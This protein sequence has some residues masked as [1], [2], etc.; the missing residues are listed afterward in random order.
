[1]DIYFCDLC[2]V[3]VT[4][5]DLRSGHGIRSRFDVI[6]GTCLELGHGK[7][8][9]SQRAKPKVGATAAAGSPTLDA[10]RDRVG[11]LE[12]D[13]PRPVA[14][15]IVQADAAPAAGVPIE[16]TPADA[17]PVLQETDLTSTAKVRTPGAAEPMNLA[18]AANMFSAL[19]EAP[20]PAAD[21]SR[22]NA[23]I[24]DDQDDLADAAD[25]PASEDTSPS[26]AQ[27]VIAEAASPFSFKSP[28]KDETVSTP[29]L[30]DDL[31]SEDEALAEVE[32]VRKDK[33]KAASNRHK[34]AGTTS[35]RVPKPAGAG[36]KKSST[37]KSARSRH[38]GGKDHSKAILLI[39]IA[40]LVLIGIGFAVVAASKGGGRGGPKTEDWAASISKTITETRDEVNGALRS[41]DLAKLTAALSSLQRTANEVDAFSKKAESNGV[42]EDAINH[43]LERTL[44]WN[45]L[46]MQSR[47]LRDRIQVLKARQG[48]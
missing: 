24:A 5:G 44:R 18:F 36:G 20:K 39:S 28:E 38:G 1:M 4:D 29:V 2:G 6:C 42:S 22:A 37:A 10:A 13:P 34:K 27:Q 47:T 46:Y 45:D 7:D 35:S 21:D 26:G 11:T 17:P 43:H 41:D 30:P 19:G 33:D 12:E 3:R 48:N 14:A 15:R 32:E 25:R 31:K 40:L 16:P 9:L 23:A 8:W